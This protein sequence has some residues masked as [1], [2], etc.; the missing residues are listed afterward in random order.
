MMQLDDFEVGRDR[1]AIPKLIGTF[2]GSAA[3][4]FRLKS[5]KEDVFKNDF[6]IEI[7]DE[8]I[9]A[10]HKLIDAKSDK[11]DD[12]RFS[13]EAQFAEGFDLNERKLLAVVLPDVYL[14]NKEISTRIEKD[15]AATILS[16]AIYPLNVTHYYYAIYERV[17]QFYKD[18]GFYDV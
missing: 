8:E 12:R 4:Y 13:I 10:L 17:E 18:R 7:L 16:Y 14:E 15:L 2:F 3:N 6:Q 11:Y 5:I 1:S 9:I